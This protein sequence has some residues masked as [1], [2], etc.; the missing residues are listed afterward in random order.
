MGCPGKWRQELKPTFLWCFVILSHT[1][2]IFGQTHWRQAFVYDKGKGHPNPLGW[3]HCCFNSME[4]GTHS[5]YST[6][7]PFFLFV[8][9]RCVLPVR[10][11]EQYAASGPYLDNKRVLREWRCYQHSISPCLCC[12]LR[13]CS[14]PNHAS[15]E[16]LKLQHR[17]PGV[18]LPLIISLALLRSL[19]LFFSDNLTD[20]TSGFP[21]LLV[22]HVLL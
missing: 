2:V 6:C 12:T 10:L 3:C 9:L 8:G 1:H 11:Y 21:V 5:P 13:A 7:T 17:F 19:W 16:M 4:T 14:I 20:L 22:K 18:D 15:S